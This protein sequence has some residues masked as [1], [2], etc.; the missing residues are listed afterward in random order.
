MSRPAIWI[1]LVTALSVDAFA[2]INVDIGTMTFGRGS[3]RTPA[4][5][6][7]AFGP[8]GT[9]VSLD[10]LLARSDGETL[11]VVLSDHRVVR[12]RL[13]DR[14]KYQPDSLP[15]KLS[16]F[17]VTDAVSVESE[18]DS[19][20]FLVARSLR[21]IRK[22]S[23]EEKAEILQSPEFRQRWRQ[24]VLS[25]E[26]IDL[27]DDDRK[28]DLVAKPAAIFEVEPDTP[29]PTS[30]AVF[31]ADAAGDELI[32]LAR[33]KVNDAY[34]RLPNFRAKLVTSLFHSTS[35]PVKWIPDDVVASEIA[36]EEQHESYS[37]IRIDGKR[38]GNAPAIADPDYMRSLDKAWSTGDFESLSHCVF[39]E[40]ED[41]DFHK[42][43]TDHG[44]QGD[45]EVYEFSRGSP[46]TC[47]AVLSKSQVAYPAYKGSLKIKPQTREVV[48][49]ELEATGM[50]ASFPLDRAERS[51]DFNKVE[52]GGEQFLLPAT[53]YWF[54]CFRN[55]YSC[56]LNRMDFRDY[57]RFEANSTV[58]FGGT[59]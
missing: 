41:A 1:C 5:P 9:H 7:W 13:E 6:G 46:S 19:K 52:I 34:D 55:T 37:D 29:N 16:T 36:Y 43:R 10:G 39:S 58:R 44:P 42:L 51:A 20:G 25:S 59:Q 47:V 50:P 49:I 15:E 26:G 31:H 23:A 53:S 38:P 35:K 14:T 40:L 54:G 18:V 8:P 22:A 11:S 24:N 48:H 17:H 30:S 45:L 32:P 2:Q 57:R 4:S 56:F 12:F 28:L 21:F 33:R 27:A 3:V